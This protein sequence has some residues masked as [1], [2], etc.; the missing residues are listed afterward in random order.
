MSQPPKK[1]VYVDVDEAAVCRSD[2]TIIPPKYRMPV[3]TS[4]PVLV[5]SEGDGSLKEPTDEDIPM[6]EEA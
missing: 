3:K 4:R 2:G 6:E 5:F 1:V